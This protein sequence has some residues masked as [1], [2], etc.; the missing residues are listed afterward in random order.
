MFRKE[1]GLNYEKLLSSTVVPWKTVILI[2]L[3]TIV[4]LEGIRR[5]GAKTFFY[6]SFTYKVHWKICEILSGLVS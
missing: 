2:I 4:V 6:T 5:Q 3:T 1:K